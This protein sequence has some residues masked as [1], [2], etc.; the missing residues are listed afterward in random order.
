MKIV[1]DEECTN[2]LSD[3]INNRVERIAK[4]GQWIFYHDETGNVV[5]E[6]ANSLEIIEE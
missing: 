1:L 3:I 2:A 5:M 4:P 6:I